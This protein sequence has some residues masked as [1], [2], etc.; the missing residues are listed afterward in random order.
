[1]LALVACSLIVATLCGVTP[2]AGFRAGAA[3]SNITPSLGRPIV[4]NPVE[5]LSTNV[6]DEFHARCLVLDD[7]KTKLALVVLDLQ[8][9]EAG[10][11]VETRG[12]IEK[13]VG[14]SASNVLISAVHTH[15]PTSR[16]LS[17]FRFSSLSVPVGIPP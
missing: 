10:M 4:G 8:G 3:R 16:R 9:T 2:G 6:H 13:Q 15:S 5:P 14:I 12:L 1:M 7:G 17:F 11:C